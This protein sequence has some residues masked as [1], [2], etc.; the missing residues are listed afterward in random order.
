M[1]PANRKIVPK[2]SFSVELMKEL[3]RTGDRADV[4]FLV[5]DK[6]KLVKAHKAILEKASD[7]FEKM[8]PFDEA[9]A[10]AAAA[11]GTGSSKKIKPVEVPEVVVPEVEVDAF[12]AMLAFI[13]AQ[14]LSGLN[15]ENVF[16]VL[17]AADKYNLP[18]LVN[19]C[20]NFIWKLNV[21][22]AFDQAR[23][24]GQEH[25]D[26]NAD[27]LILSEAF[28]QI[29]HKLL[30]EILDRD[31]LCQIYLIFI[32]P[33][34]NIWLNFAFDVPSGVL[35]KDEQA[36]VY[37]YHS[38]PNAG[39]PEFSQLQFPTNGRALPGLTLQNRWDSAAR[40]EKLALS[41][42]ARLIVQFIGKEKE[43]RS[44]LAEWPIPKGKFGIFYYEMKII[45]NADGIHI[46]LATKQMPLD[47]WVG[48]DKGTSYSYDSRGLFWG[49]AFKDDGLSFAADDV[50]GCGVDLA[51]G[52][53]IYTKNGQRL[54]LVIES[55]GKVWGSSIG[56][57]WVSCITH[58]FGSIYKFLEF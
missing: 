4:H 55:R 22:F 12:K 6:K 51:T 58:Y 5:G 9:N 19:S 26:E 54:G 44:V 33:R 23:F 35:E 38:H 16:S 40:H 20:L 42:P 45:G 14:D 1:D 50:V 49:H 52:Q 48:R 27:A 7:V 10:K 28:L 24:L 17:Y 36:G 29:D 34:P 21:F 56:K 57:F 2:E 13:Y 11:A 43:W 47:T 37:Q 3:L 15:G 53:I 39:L 18:A 46:G 30:C 41:E 8:F 25:I 32:I 31:E